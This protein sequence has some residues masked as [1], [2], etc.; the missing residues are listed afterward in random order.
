MLRAP[1]WR[2]S[3]LSISV[4]Q[5]PVHLPRPRSANANM[6]VSLCVASMEGYV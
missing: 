5:M 6:M 4:L 3:P 2:S 1:V